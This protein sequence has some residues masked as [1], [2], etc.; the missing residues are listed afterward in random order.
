MKLTI[1]SN[2][3]VSCQGVLFAVFP[4]NERVSFWNFIVLASNKLVNS[5]ILIS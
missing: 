4:L 3:S 2:L 1:S 5:Q